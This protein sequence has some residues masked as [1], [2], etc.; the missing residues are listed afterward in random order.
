[1]VEIITNQTPFYAESGGQVGDS[2][3][4]SG[5]EVV[6]TKKRVGEIH[7]HICKNNGKLPKIGDVVELKINSERRNKVKANHSATHLLH[8]VLRNTLGDHV[9][10]KGSL[11]EA[12]YLRFDFSH[13][14]S[15]SAEQL[16]AIDLKVN[17]LVRENTE[18]CT[19]LMTPEEAKKAGA[20]AL[21]GEKYGDEVRVLTMG[22]EY[23][24]EL[25]G[26]TH[27]NRT[28]DI[29]LFRIISESSIASGVRRI[30]AITGEA[31]V[32]YALEKGNII[33]NLSFNLKVKPQEL[34]ERVSAVQA[35]VKAL[36]KQLAEAKK[37]AALG[38]AGVPK[39]DPEQIGEFKFYG[40][41]FEGLEPND[42]RGIAE[43]LRKKEPDA[44]IA[45]FGVNEGKIS[46]V[47]AVG[48]NAKAKHD[49]PSLVK[50]ASEATGGKGGGGRPELA[51]AGG[52]EVD[53]I[54][55]AIEAVKGEIG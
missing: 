54:E 17:R 30:E 35:Q 45:F 25:C 1:M 38:G 51:Q 53:K 5:L 4:L 48:D 40:H 46:I 10:Q 34:E 19:A 43:D 55:T 52:V 21:F 49:A 7:S 23:S 28:G 31:A 27:V 2:G 15:L 44:I 20:M 24:M 22:G 42:V 11:V 37:K 29:G 13:N 3:T 6:D 36:E 18:V 12:D 50:I 8:A 14:E 16:Q 26:G 32:R 9:T 39:I 41:K 33:N 47:T